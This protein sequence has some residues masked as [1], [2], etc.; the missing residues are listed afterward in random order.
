M[1]RWAT[2]IPFASLSDPNLHPV[3]DLD[4]KLMSN[5]HPVDLDP[6]LTSK[7]DPNPKKSDQILKKTCL[8]KLSAC[9]QL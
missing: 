7:A 5:R 1:K 8:P 4:P 2:D 6:K 3:L 9:L